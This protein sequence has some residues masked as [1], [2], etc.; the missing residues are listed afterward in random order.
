MFTPMNNCPGCTC[1][2]VCPAHDPP[3]PGPHRAKS[4]CNRAALLRRIQ[5]EFAD[6][7]G[8]I[9]PPSS[10]HRLTAATLATTAKIAEIR[11][12][13]APPGACPVRNLNPGSS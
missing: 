1:P 5:T 10:L 3:D 12:I 9:A 6:R 11:V 13:D 8:C 2:T 4:P 7:E